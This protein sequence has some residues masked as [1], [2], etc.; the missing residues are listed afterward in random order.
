[1]IN[2]YKTELVKQN[3]DTEDTEEQNNEYYNS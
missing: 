2:K 1:M 3:L